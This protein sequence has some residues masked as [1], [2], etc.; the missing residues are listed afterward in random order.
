MAHSTGSY[1]NQDAE[2]RTYLALVR[3]FECILLLF[4]ALNNKKTCYEQNKTYI[5]IE[6]H[7]MIS[8]D[9]PP[10]LNSSQ[11]MV[12]TFNV[13]FEFNTLGASKHHTRSKTFFLD[14][15]FSYFAYLYIF[16]FPYF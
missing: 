8:P 14:Y 12:P 10:K 3:G 7:K 5:G 9:R 6:Y 13:E 16:I 11:V 1:Y 2:E 4:K 15:M